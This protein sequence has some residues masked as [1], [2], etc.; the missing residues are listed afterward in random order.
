MKNLDKFFNKTDTPWVKMI[1]DYGRNTITLA[2][3]LGHPEKDLFGRE[4]F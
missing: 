2:G 1:W 4:I 3:F